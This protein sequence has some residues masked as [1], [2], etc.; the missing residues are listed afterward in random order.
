MHFILFIKK[1]FKKQ[2]TPE[3]AKKLIS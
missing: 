1:F 3:F 2:K